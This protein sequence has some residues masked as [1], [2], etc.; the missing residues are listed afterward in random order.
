VAAGSDD[1][2]AIAELDR[3]E[4]QVIS[5]AGL[6]DRVSTLADGL[7]RVGVRP[8][9]RIAL[10]VPPGLDLTTTVYACWQAGAVIVVADAGL[11]WRRMADSLRS[12][13]PDYLIGIPAAVAAA[14]TFQLPGV[15]V[16]AGEVPRHLRQRLGISHSI[17]ELGTAGNLDPGSA[18]SSEAA[19]LFTS[20]A[21]G[22][23]KGVVYRHQQLLAQLEQVR[24]LCDVNPGDRLVAAFA[25]FALYGPALGIGA[26]VPRMDVTKPGTLT[27]ARL[28]VAERRRHLS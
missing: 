22:P 1:C 21:T 7:R 13:D 9:H 11:G 5:F 10:L 14:A 6:R 15:R 26:V 3:G 20:G 27:A 19:V 25:P 12:A 24:A 16:V 2:P 28:A 18:Q 4:T 8:G 23:P 17:E